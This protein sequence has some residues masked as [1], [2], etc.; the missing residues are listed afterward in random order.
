MGRLLADALD[1]ELDVVLSHKIGSPSN[2][3]FAV[4][5]VSEDGEVYIAPYAE[6]LGIPKPMMER[7]AREQLQALKERRRLYTPYRSACDAKGRVV[8]LVDDG[9]ATGSTV[10]SA[11]HQV[12]RQHPKKIIVASAIAP[13]DVVRKLE[14]EA[15][16]VVVLRVEMNFGAVGELFEDFSQ[17]SDDEVIECLQRP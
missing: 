9:I 17:V 1:G 12:R 15:D 10:L 16:E 5:A 3:E 7:A 14:R 8:I 2:P 11:I 13:P 4:G 6:Q